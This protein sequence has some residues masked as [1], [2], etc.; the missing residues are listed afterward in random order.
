MS[1]PYPE[2]MFSESSKVAKYLESKSTVSGE[3]VDRTWSAV[4]VKSEAGL[5]A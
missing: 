3:G 5:E 2:E 1:G 4:Q